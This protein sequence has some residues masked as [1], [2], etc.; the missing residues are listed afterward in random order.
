MHGSRGW[1]I[2]ECVGKVRSY[3]V[4]F[5]R[6]S[7]LGRPTGAGSYIIFKE[8]WTILCD[9]AWCKN[10]GCGGF[11]AVAM[12]DATNFACRAGWADNCASPVEAEL[13]DVLA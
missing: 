1:S 3:E 7:I 9:G 10:M 5:H 8:K 11:T 6:C 2:E 12:K 13:R 4:I